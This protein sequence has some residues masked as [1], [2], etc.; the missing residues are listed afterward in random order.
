MGLEW[1]GLGC[2]GRSSWHYPYEERDARLLK[3]LPPYELLVGH[4]A[5][6][7]LYLDTRDNFL[8][9]T[10]FGFQNDK[11]WGAIADD[12]VALGQVFMVDDFLS[13]IHIKAP[14]VYNSSIKHPRGVNKCRKS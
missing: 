9:L 12:S 5:L 3:N 8:N 7:S 6:W 13:P 1:D 4:A 10:S 14:S 2:R 11:V